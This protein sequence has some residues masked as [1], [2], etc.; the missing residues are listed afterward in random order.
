MGRYSA[1]V[2]QLSLETQ[3]LREAHDVLSASGR[4][5]RV[6]EQLADPRSLIVNLAS[7]Y[8]MTYKGRFRGTVN[9]SY[10]GD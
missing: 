3:L 2:G 9:A 1:I 5:C 10:S 8:S 4:L 7:C 6:S